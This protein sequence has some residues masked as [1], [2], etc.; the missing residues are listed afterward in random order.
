M[1]LNSDDVESQNTSNSSSINLIGKLSKS[2]LVERFRVVV[3]K[4]TEFAIY[5][6]M[7]FPYFYLINI[8]INMITI[9]ILFFQN[10]SMK[11]I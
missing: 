4:A 7:K 9:I 3:T 8:C 6:G 11:K 5:A 2:D 1:S 10:Q